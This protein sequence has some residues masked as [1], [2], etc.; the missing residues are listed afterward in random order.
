MSERASR[1][2]NEDIC[3]VCGLD[4]SAKSRYISPDME[5]NMKYKKQINTVSYFGDI[6][7]GSSVHTLYKCPK[8]KKFCYTDDTDTS[9]SKMN[10]F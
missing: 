4:L 9:P 1:V 7:L 10:V 5:K 6:C 8:C 3:A 2:A